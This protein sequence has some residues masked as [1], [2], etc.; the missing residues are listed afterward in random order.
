MD[1]LQFASAIGTVSRSSCIYI[2]RNHT[3]RKVKGPVKDTHGLPPTGPSFAEFFPNGLKAENQEALIEKYGNIFT[4]PSPIPGVV[5]N[6]VVIN[7]P[8]LV[9]ELCIRQANMYRNPSNFT[10]RGDIFAKVTREVVGTGVTG[11]KG[12]EW[13]WRKRALLKEFHRNRLLADERGLLAAVIE[14]GNILCE[15]LGKAANSKKPI[16]VDYLTTK[17]AVGVVLFFLFGRHLEFDTAEMRSSAKDM[18]DHCLKS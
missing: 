15:E 6:Q 1:Q 10:T 12:D 9:K 18:I 4:V 17:A 8:A 7:E 14:E 5:P 2:H 13:H 11:L 16:A 3:T